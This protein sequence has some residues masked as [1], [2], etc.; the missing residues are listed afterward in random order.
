M[1]HQVRPTN[2]AILHAHR[3]F[4]RLRRELPDADVVMIAGNHD[5]P[6]SSEL[7][8]ILRLFTP[9]GIHVADTEAV[10]FDF[11]NRDLT[12]LAVPSSVFDRT[13]LAPTSERRFNVLVAHGS[14]EGEP[15]PPGGMPR[16]EIK[17]RDL[18]VN[19]WSYIA[20]GHHHV[21]SGLADNQFYAGATDYTGKNVWGEKQEEA[22]KRWKGKC[23]IEFNL[24][25]GVHEKHWIKG[26]RAFIDLTPVR[27]RGKTAD[28]INA[29]IKEA[30]D[31]CPGGIDEKV[32][33][34][35]VLDIPRH[36]TRQLDHRM[37]REYRRRALHFQFDPRKPETL[38]PGQAGPGR[39]AS[40]AD[41][42]RDKLRE[43]VIPPDV[44]RDALVTLGLHYL[45]EAEERETYTTPVLGT[46]N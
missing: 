41:L 44:D 16:V 1:F 8:C 12:V 43:R 28:E 4:S 5:T 39:R 46:A 27:A 23:I 10:A 31:R 17:Q 9:L 20:L 24:E 32:V 6:R 30:V 38:R 26:E 34:L 22:E 2:T 7:V 21:V 25:T 33:R 3:E 29:Y 42:V 19:Q 36:I 15:P 11:P 35:T 45:A 37:L 40:L 14:V 18:H 13:R